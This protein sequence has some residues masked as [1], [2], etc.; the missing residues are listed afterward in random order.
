MSISLVT[1][2][3]IA[4]VV[5][6]ILVVAALFGY[7]T[8][9]RAYRVAAPN[10]ALIITGGKAK[11]AKGDI[12]LESATRIVVGGRVFVR[13]LLDR[14]Y[15]MDLSSRQ[16]GVQ[17]EA[18]S[19]NSIPLVLEGVAQ[20]KVGEDI[21][22]IRRAA[23]RF[24]DQQ[25]DIDKYSRELLSGTM[26]SAVGTL[27][28]EQILRD[29][30]TF[31]EKI[32]EDALESMNNQGLVLDTFQIIS[33]E[34]RDGTY[35]RDLGRPEAAAA[36][37]R[38]SIAESEANRE[39][40]EAQN[41]NAQLIADSQKELELR[42][43]AIQQETA[44]QKAEAEAAEQLAKAEQ[45]QRILAEQQKIAEANNDLKERQLVAEVRKP[46]DAKKY[47]SQQTADA[48]RYAREQA[49]EAELTESQR[50][51]DAAQAKG[52]A[53]AAIVQQRAEAEA[54]ATR[55]KGEAEAL[56]VE[57][58]GRAEASAAAEKGR[59]E[60]ESIAAAADAYA[61]Y[62]DAA[63]LSEVLKVLPEIA[64]RL[65]EPYGNIEK[66]SV[67]STDGESK[68]TQNAAVNLEKTID[69]VSST[70]GLD[71]HGLLGS[72]MDRSAGTDPAATPRTR[73]RNEAPGAPAGTP[74]ASDE[75]A[76]KR[77]EP[78]S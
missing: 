39:A 25:D 34:D 42:Q 59:A 66:L 7:I 73:T 60:A 74:D 16:I 31:A 41:R 50:R 45:Q 72:L 49:A 14:A 67:I 29:R 37:K 21:A 24:L 26:R 4:L 78:T 19:S 62:T 70:T 57:A 68:L 36:A 61:K 52:R 15:S 63:R 69:M 10:E 76:Q 56:A 32:R 1:G 30:A 2:G 71:V 75:A 18:M 38:A 51:A 65:V 11:K 8:F 53:D 48:Q 13:P 64:G 44:S 58:R 40:T 54:S 3:G 43:A 27:T 6:V 5:L 35:L 17:I 77:D 23:Q 55:A 47:E 12:D 20:I 22:D 9:R 33:I 46:A 28:V